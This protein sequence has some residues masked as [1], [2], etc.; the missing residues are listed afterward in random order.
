MPYFNALYCAAI[1]SLAERREKLSRKFFK[2]S[3]QSKNPHLAFLASYLTHGIPP[4]QLD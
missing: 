3:N 2:S 1:P 4:L